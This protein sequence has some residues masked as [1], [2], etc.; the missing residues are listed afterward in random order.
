MKKTAGFSL[1]EVMIAVAV[2]T[3]IAFVIAQVVILSNRSMKVMQVAMDAAE[4]YGRVGVILG[5]P[6]QCEASIGYG[7]NP[8]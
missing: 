6:L 3:L 4:Y 5:Q 7:H 2:S 8:L 1:V